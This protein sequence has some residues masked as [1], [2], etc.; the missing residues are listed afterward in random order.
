M[1]CKKILLPP[2]LLPPILLPPKIRKCID[3]TGSV[4]AILGM[5]PANYLGT[6]ASGAAVGGLIPSLL[7]IAIIGATGN[8]GQ[9][10]GFSCF[11]LSTLISLSCLP[12]TFTLQR[13]QFFRFYGGDLF[14]KNNHPCIQVTYNMFKKRSYI[15]KLFLMQ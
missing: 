2:I 11:C 3:L 8:S 6:M 14:S 1:W 13:N 7:N 10:V 15:F 12:L 5:F 4:A 9:I